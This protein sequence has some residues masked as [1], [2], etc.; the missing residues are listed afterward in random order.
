MKLNVVVAVT[1]QMAPLHLNQSCT[2]A[3]ACILREHCTVEGAIPWLGAN[4]KS[5]IMCGH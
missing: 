1:L 3:S 5:L 4:M 2:N